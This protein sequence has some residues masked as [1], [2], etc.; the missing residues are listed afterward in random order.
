M[1]CFADMNF[2]AVI[3]DMDGTLFDTEILY[4][5]AFTSVLSEQGIELEEDFY[6]ANLAGTTN[7]HI[8][9]YLAEIYGEQFRLDGF[10]VGWPV[11]LKEIL[12]RDG[13]PFMEGI[14]ELLDELTAKGTRMAVASSSDVEEIEDFLR[15]AGIREIFETVA[16][17]N[18]VSAS[19]PAPD[20][21]ELAAKRL[22]VSAGD[23]LAI[24]DSNHGV[25]AAHRAGMSVVM[26][27]GPAGA[28]EK[29]REV[30]IFLDDLVGGVL[31]FSFS[32]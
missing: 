23:C 21:F 24:E 1:S 26:C 4:Y 13:L 19:K 30:A 5:R 17:G 8:E 27:P 10:R 2:T 14:V 28:N 7:R 20:V 3:F 16:G 6:H 9:D 25:L 32:G 18:E 29:S 12:D 15:R 31:G 11:R 22:G